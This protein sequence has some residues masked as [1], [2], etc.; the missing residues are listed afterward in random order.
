M[1][2]LALLARPQT[3]SGVGSVGLPLPLQSCGRAK[4]RSLL[5]L[6]RVCES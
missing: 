6:Q 2:L 1:A 5:Q 4:H 3:P